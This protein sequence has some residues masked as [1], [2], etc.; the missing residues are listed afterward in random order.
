MS[1][2]KSNQLV[3]CELTA[4]GWEGIVSEAAD[5]VIPG[6][7]SKRC[8]ICKRYVRPVLLGGFPVLRSPKNENKGRSFLEG[9][10]I[11]DPKTGDFVDFV[12]KGDS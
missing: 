1:T 9:M 10:K 6:D 3:S 4:C 7:P 8:P 12:K 2:V 5:S 11:Q